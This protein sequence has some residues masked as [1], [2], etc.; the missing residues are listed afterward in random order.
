MPEIED[1]DE[2][3]ITKETNRKGKTTISVNVVSPVVSHMY[4]PH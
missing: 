2:S 3:K 1:K 4:R